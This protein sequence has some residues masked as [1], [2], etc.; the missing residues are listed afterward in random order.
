M[1]QSACRYAKQH[2]KHIHINQELILYVD[3]A[4]TLYRQ[5]FADAE[6]HKLM[7]N[8]W[9]RFGSVRFLMINLLS[10][11]MESNNLYDLYRCKSENKKNY[12]SSI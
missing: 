6:G 11:C 10:K 3:A 4:D 7:T 1:D 5:W 2:R 9:V 12:T 8:I